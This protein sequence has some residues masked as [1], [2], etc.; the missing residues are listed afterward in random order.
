V[1]TVFIDD[2]TTLRKVRRRSWLASTAIATAP[3][4]AGRS[5]LTSWW[6]AARLRP[7]GAFAEALRMLGE[8]T[9]KARESVTAIFPPKG[10]LRYR[11]SRLRSG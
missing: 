2:T 7:A 8:K 1:T 9:R 6:V 10:P 5:V 3:A 11:A 4:T